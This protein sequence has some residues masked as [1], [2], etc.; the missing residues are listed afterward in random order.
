M[1]TDCT[2]LICSWFS[3][4]SEALINLPHTTIRPEAFSAA[5]GILRWQDNENETNVFSVLT[6]RQIVEKLV[7]PEK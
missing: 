7:D 5:D 3:I 4:C 6:P 2:T 1:F